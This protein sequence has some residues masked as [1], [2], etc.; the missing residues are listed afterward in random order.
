MSEAL[1]RHHEETRDAET[2]KTR[3]TR[4]AETP[5]M[6]TRD[7]E[8][9]DTA[10]QDEETCELDPITWDALVEAM[11]KHGVTHEVTGRICHDARRMVNATP[12]AE[13][14]RLEAEAEEAFAERRAG[15]R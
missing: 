14:D 12:V 15:L 8:T 7:T 1:P 4:G 9:R 10:A 2:Q 11:R 13:R 5:D 3:E 6:E